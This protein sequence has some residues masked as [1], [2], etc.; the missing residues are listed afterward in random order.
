VARLQARLDEQLQ[1]GD[2]RPALDWLRTT[3]QLDEGSAEQLL[4][5]LAAPPGARRPALAGHAGDGALFR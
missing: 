5:Y 4:D 3:Y 2:L 1:A